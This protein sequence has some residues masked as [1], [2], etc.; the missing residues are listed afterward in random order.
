MSTMKTSVHLVNDKG[1][2]LCPS[3]TAKD[4]MRRES[5]DKLTQ[6]EQ[7]GSCRRI[8]NRQEGRERV[9]FGTVAPNRRKDSTDSDAAS[10]TP[11]HGQ[12]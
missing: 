8:I 5:W 9:S 4:K 7:C 6:Q 3:K 1:A 12:Q 10:Y 11:R 2:I